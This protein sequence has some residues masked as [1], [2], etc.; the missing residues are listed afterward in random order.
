MNSQDFDLDDPDD[1]D[2]LDM[3]VDIGDMLMDLILVTTKIQDPRKLQ[4][5]L[6]RYGIKI[7]TRVREKDQIHPDT[8]MA[9]SLE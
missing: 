1:K 4:K 8:N 3:I 6:T 7:A 2:E 9:V 5:E